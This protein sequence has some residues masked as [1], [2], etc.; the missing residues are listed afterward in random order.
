MRSL[1]K[2]LEY[3][4][5]THNEMI[6]VYEQAVKP[7]H[8][9]IRQLKRTPAVYAEIREKAAKGGKPP[10]P[11]HPVYRLGAPPDVPS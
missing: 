4:D 5:E 11:K 9:R 2:L 6:E 7:L 10:P 8:L 1:S 3:R